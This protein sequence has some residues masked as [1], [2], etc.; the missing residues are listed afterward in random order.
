M[1]IGLLLVVAIV[2]YAVRGI[3]R[4]VLSERRAIAEAEQEETISAAEASDRAQADARAG[5]YRNAAR[6]LYLASLLWLEEHG[7][8]RYDR[9]RTNH[10]YLAQVRGKQ[11]YDDLAPVVD[12]F[13][14]V[15]YG[16][17]PLDEQGFQQ[18]EQQVAALQE[19]GSRQP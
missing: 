3:R 2:I 5:D 16:Q 13:E 10:E 1:L 15:W 14:R 4:S 8:L 17:R 12:T 11:V 9:S 18:Y 19:Q 6:H 7:M